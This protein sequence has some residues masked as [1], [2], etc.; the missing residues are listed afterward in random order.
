MGLVHPSKGQIL[1]ASVLGGILGG[2][3]GNLHDRILFGGVRDFID[4]HYHEVYHWPTFNLADSFLVCGAHLPGGGFVFSPVEEIK[5]D[6]VP[7]AG[8]K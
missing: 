4:A 1:L 7:T 3:A 5:S 8:E 2:A 6:P